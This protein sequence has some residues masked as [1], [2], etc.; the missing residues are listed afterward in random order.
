MKFIKLKESKI[1]EPNTQIVVN[2]IGDSNILFE[3]SM[4][5][6]KTYE[7]QEI[8]CIVQDDKELVIWLK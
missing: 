6:C 4:C 3:G 1:I 7:F 2:R 8:D 5:A